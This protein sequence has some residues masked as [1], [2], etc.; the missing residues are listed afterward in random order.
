MLYRAEDGSHEEWIWNSRDGATP[1]LIEARNGRSSMKHVEWHRDKYVPCYVPMVGE[2]VFV[3]ITPELAAQKARAV[4]EKTWDES[5]SLARYAGET[6]EKAIEAIAEAWYKPGN[7]TVF[8]TTSE[9]LAVRS[10]ATSWV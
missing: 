4:V 7:P 2:R 9:W 6:K 3:D 10:V 1:F 8:E 5:G